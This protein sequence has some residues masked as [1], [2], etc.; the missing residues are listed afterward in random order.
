MYSSGPSC[1][2]HAN[3]R[4][5]FTVKSQ[6]V[7]TAHQ[8]RQI[9]IASYN[10][11]NA[12]RDEKVEETKWVN[13]KD[14]VTD[15]IGLIDPAVI[16]L[17]ELR[18]LPG[19]KETV[20]QY[21]ASSFP[22]Y[23][24]DIR[25]RNPGELS[26]AQVIMW[27]PKILFPLCKVHKWISNSPGLVSDSVTMPLD[28]ESPG[29]LLQAVEF[30]FVK[31]GKVVTDH[32]GRQ[33]PFWVFNTHL[34]VE[35]SVKNASCP[36]LLNLIRDIT[37][38]AAYVLCGDFNTFDDLDGEKQ[39]DVF[40]KAGLIDLGTKMVS[41]DS[42]DEIKG[43]FVGFLQD[44]HHAKDPSN[45]TSRLDHI[46]ASDAR[47]HIQGHDAMDVWNNT[48]IDDNED[49]DEPKEGDNNKL[50]SDHLPISV[51]VYITPY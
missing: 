21:I 37:F 41:A 13:R 47:I 42:H 31:D 38:G 29:Y 9:R 12:K 46:W 22:G 19:A 43:T 17:Q 20:E 28:K 25:Y 40:R 34:G 27:D 48:M 10:V 45:P 32:M 49:G 8:H 26:F 2:Q 14:R 35:E 39:R 23:R 36:I 50:P 33:N 51:D 6:D 5:R 11:S 3:G 44:P 16:C 7:A 24:A 1:A 4:D 15:L 30:V 18:N